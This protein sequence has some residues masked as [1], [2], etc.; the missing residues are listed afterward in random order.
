MRNYMRKFG[1]CNR[2]SLFYFGNERSYDSFTGQKVQRKERKK[3]RR[4]VHI[5][6]I[7]C[8]VN[9]VSSAIFSLFRSRL[10]E[11]KNNGLKWAETGPIKVVMPKHAFLLLFFSLPKKNTPSFAC[12]KFQLPFL[13]FPRPYSQC[14]T[15]TSIFD[16]EPHTETSTVS[17][18]FLPPPHFPSDY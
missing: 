1:G 10:I 17:R 2:N 6:V 7:Y 4:I 15:Q 8:V 13:F 9:F 5:C 12:S 3:K 11:M 16:A 14:H 18:A